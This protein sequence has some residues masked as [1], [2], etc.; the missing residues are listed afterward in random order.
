MNTKILDE[1]AE[2]IGQ[3]RAKLVADA[4][5]N[6]KVDLDFPQLAQGDLTHVKKSIITELEEVGTILKELD[7]E[8]INRDELVKMI[9]VCAR[10]LISKSLPEAFVTTI[11]ELLVTEKQ[12]SNELED[13]IK[14]IKGVL[15]SLQRRNEEEFE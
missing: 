6:K 9:D 11:S 2:L 5:F 7:G 3:D 12:M 8:V 1:W 14:H 10:D 15:D 13:E 4:F